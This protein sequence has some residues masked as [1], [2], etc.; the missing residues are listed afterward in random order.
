MINSSKDYWK[1][2]R[3]LNLC[4]SWRTRSESLA[5]PLGIE[6]TEK[7]FQSFEDY[8]EQLIREIGDFDC[9]RNCPEKDIGKRS[10]KSP[11]K[12]SGIHP[13]SKPDTVNKL[14]GDLQMCIDLGPNLVKARFELHYSQAEFGRLFGFTQQQISRYENSCYATLSLA[15]ATSLA[16]LLSR[17]LKTHQS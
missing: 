13:E 1:A 10:G 16:G 2:R 3:Q 14:M 11:G 17:Q 7:L 6:N 4:I 5:R 12:H 15:K 8:K 9:L